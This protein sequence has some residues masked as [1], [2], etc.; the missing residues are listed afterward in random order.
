MTEQEPRAGSA[1]VYSDNIAVNWRAVPDELDETHLANLD[2]S[3][4]EFLRALAVFDDGGSGGGM[5]G[6]AGGGIGSDATGHTS[7]T[8][9]AHRIDL[10]LNL[11]LDLVA[12]LVYSQ[13]L[14]PPTTPVELT[15]SDVTWRGASVPAPRQR[16]FLEIYIQRGLPKAFCCYADI[17]S[18]DQQF[19]DGVAKASFVGLSGAVR[20]WLEKLIFRHHRREVA[21]LRSRPVA[22]ST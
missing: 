14:I 20:G 16:V 1:L 5:G 13:G 19:D 2:A 18:S 9:E 22:A 8:E 3:N 15:A 7:L 11:L 6:G 21:Y 10:K 17:V 4:E 12:A